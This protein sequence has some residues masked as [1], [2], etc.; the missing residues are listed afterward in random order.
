MRR[1]QQKNQ[2]ILQTT[3]ALQLQQEIQVAQVA[4]RQLRASK[5]K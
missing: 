4:E 3:Q 5:Y 1:N 2:V